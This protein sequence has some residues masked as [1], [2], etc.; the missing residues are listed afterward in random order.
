MFVD[1]DNYDDSYCIELDDATEIN[2]YLDGDENLSIINVNIRSLKKNYSKLTT[3]LSQLKF[4]PK[5]ITVTETWLRVE[6]EKILRIKGYN[7]FSISRDHD[8][9]KRVKS[10]GG[11]RIYFCENLNVEIVTELSGVFDSHESLFVRFTTHDTGKILFGA[12]YRPT[13]SLFK[14]SYL[15]YKIGYLMNVII[16]MRNV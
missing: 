7:Q 8:P 15:T 10:G 12:I 6:H 2:S 1:N 16:M 13:Q 4:K 14:V 11:L 5:I 3:F 9:N